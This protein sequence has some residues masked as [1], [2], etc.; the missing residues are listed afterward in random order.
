MRVQIK[1]VKMVPNT[2]SEFRDTH[3][4]IAHLTL[5]GAENNEGTCDVTMHKLR[6]YRGL[7]DILLQDTGLLLHYQKFEA[8][9]GAVH[10]EV[11][12][13]QWRDFINKNYLGK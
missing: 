2:N 10:E 7:Q 11:L 1:S 3:P 12:D 5:I 6:S 9:S 4:H 8:L 13:R